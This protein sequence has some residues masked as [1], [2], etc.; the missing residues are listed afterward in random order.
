[1][2]EYSSTMPDM[3]SP[4]KPVL[5]RSKL[6]RSRYLHT[7][8]FKLGIDVLFFT[9]WSPDLLE[10]N[11]LWRILNNDLL[12]IEEISINSFDVKGDQLI[13]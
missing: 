9:I 12:E 7:K 4:A 6:V 13:V 10:E 3:I 5:W 1:M 8:M 11:Q 2:P